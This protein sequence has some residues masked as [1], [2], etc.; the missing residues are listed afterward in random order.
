[1]NSLCTLCQKNY[2]HALDAGPL[3]FQ[4]F[5]SREYLTNPFRTL[6]LCFCAM[7]KTPGLIS[8][9]NF[10]KKKRKKFLSGSAIAIISWQDVTRSSLCPGVKEIGSKRAHIVLFPSPLS[11]QK[12]CSIWDI[13]RFCY[14]SLCFS[15]VI[16]NQISNSSN[17][18][19]SL[20]RFWTATSLIIFYQL[21]SVSKSRIPLKNF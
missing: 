17:G 4:I 19:L 20:I 5:R 8:R 6:S 10:G 11:A 2:Q 14:Y 3:E 12:D 15:T 18:Y 13:Q 1:M 21:P 9:N 16:F 7:S